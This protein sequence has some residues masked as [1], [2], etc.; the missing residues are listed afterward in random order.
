MNNILSRIK[1]NWLYIIIPIIFISFL[2]I[3]LNVVYFGDDYYY[4]TFRELN[5]SDYF[6]KLFGHYQNDNG[7][8]IVHML[9]T[10]FLKAPLP[11][12][13]ILNSVFLTGICYFSSKIINFYTKN[14]SSLPYV[15]T[16][17][18]LA[19][20]DI[21]IFRE[22]VYWLT[23]SFNYVYPIFL[24]FMYWYFVSKIGGS[25]SSST[26]SINAQSNNPQSPNVQKSDIQNS[27]T[28]RKNMQDCNIKVKSKKLN[29]IKTNSTAFFALTLLV[30]FLS[31]ATVEQ[32]GMM[33][34][35]LTILLTLSSWKGFSKIKNFFSE[36]KKLI[37]LCFVTLL[38]LATVILAPSQFRRIEIENANEAETIPIGE[39]ILSN[40]VFI[41]ARYTANSGILPYCILFGI[42]TIF[43]IAKNE[44]GKSKYF[45][46]A[47]AFLNCIFTLFN[48]FYF[49]NIEVAIYVKYLFAAFDII[50]YAI[51]IFYLN[52]KIY[53]KLFSPLIIA[54][55]L[56]V[57]SQFMMIIS[58]VLGPR[59]LIFGYILFGFLIA[60]TMAH[61]SVKKMNSLVPIFLLF[62]VILNF[63]TAV[64][65]R[66]TRLIDEK[67]KDI[68]YESAEII[69][70]ENETLTL[71]RFPD[72]NYAWSMPYVSS[73]HEFYFK[74]FYK[75]KCNI[76]WE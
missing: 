44:L 51:L 7:R 64:G 58:P 60:L 33:T 22:S 31:A 35:G 37:A 15:I 65:Y 26:Q 41:I 23:G 61:L 29:A 63:N 1:E 70:N 49:D 66:S 27:K 57:G 21:S 11:F 30:G 6:S 42:V 72:D 13:A 74:Y 39:R 34:F 40:S 54:T 18:L 56:M 68:I 55:V 2:L 59:N 5:V 62:G 28:Q 16:F 36:N 69:N 67:N 8:F 76:N 43:Y 75:I 52:H 71:Y 46:I 25:T 10:L 38:G 12:W 3:N 9:V 17:F 20:L 50:S 19:V 4:L 47:F 24:F 32:C 73:Y 14:S 48:V 53:R 45:L